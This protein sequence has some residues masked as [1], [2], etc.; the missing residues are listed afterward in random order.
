[1]DRLMVEKARVNSLV[2]AFVQREAAIGIIGLG[3]VG[4]PLMLSACRSGHTVVG[5]DI[6]HEK[7]KNLNQGKS[8]L[9]HI[10]DNNI[11]RKVL[12]ECLFEATA[13]FARLSD[14][15]A[16]LICVP[17]PLDRHRQPDLRFVVETAKTIADNLG[18]EQLIFLESTYPETTRKVVKPII[19]ATSARFEKDF[20][21][22]YSPE[23]EDPG[24][25]KFA[26]TQVPKVASDAGDSALALASALYSSIFEHIVPVSSLEAAEAIKLTENIF[27][28]VN[29]ALVN[30]LKIIYSALGID[31]FDMIDGAK[32]KPFGFMPFYPGPG[33]GG[34][35]IPIDPFYLT[36]KARELGISTRFIELAGEINTS[37]PRYVSDRL[38]EELDR[39]FGKGLSGAHILLIGVAYRQLQRWGAQVDYHDPFV[40]VIPPTRKHADLAGKRSVPFDER[41]SQLAITE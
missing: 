33:L 19:E 7:I 18:R 4:L 30:E 5:F 15:Q 23:R 38:R 27:R 12:D 29:I 21:L 41:R 40:P 17:T 31:I 24:N 6:D 16:I 14:M 22:G 2:R 39:R 34:H 25:P 20:F 10:G 13:Q 8:P 28:A 37:M 35:C 9:A 36:R 32:T 26:T 1:M 11:S 3:Y